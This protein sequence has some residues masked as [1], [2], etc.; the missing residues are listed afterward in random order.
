MEGKGARYLDPKD[1]ST[2]PCWQ[3][4]D[5]PPE[6]RTEC[7]VFQYEAGYDCWEVSGT[8]CQG[9]S[10]G[11]RAQKKKLCSQCDVFRAT[12]VQPKA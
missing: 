4:R 3:A 12:L 2:K 10:L 11:S 1:W 8:Y 5:C 6:W 9:K 7:P